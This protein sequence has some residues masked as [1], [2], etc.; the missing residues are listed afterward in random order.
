MTN[1]DLLVDLAQ[2]VETND[3]IDW[4]MLSVDE[5]TAYRLIATSILEQFGDDKDRITLLATITKLVVEN[6]V[7]NLKLLQKENN[8]N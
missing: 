6:F 7:L 5:Q 1:V 2:Q 8:G 3:P 4:G